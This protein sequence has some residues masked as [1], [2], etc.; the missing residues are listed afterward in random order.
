MGRQ[1]SGKDGSD[2]PRPI[3]PPDDLTSDPARF[4]SAA[5][6]LDKIP[7]P[8]SGPSTPVLKRLGPPPFPRGSFPLLG[9]LASVYEHVGRC[10]EDTLRRASSE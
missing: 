6:P 7:P 1:K 2:A 5:V 3:C 4:W 10:A 9:F 8:L